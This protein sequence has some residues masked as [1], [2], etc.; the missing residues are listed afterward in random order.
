MHKIAFKYSFL[1][2][3]LCLLWL[4]CNKDV[5]NDF[6]VIQDEQFKYG[7]HTNPT[8]DAIGGGGCYSHAV[9]EGDYL[10]LNRS[11]LLDALSV[12]QAGEVV[13]VGP[14]AEIDLSGD[15]KIRIPEGVTLAGDRGNCNSDSEGPLLYANSM[16][17]G[18][19]LF[20]LRPGCR[21]TGLRF[22][23][24]DA[25]FSN[26]DYDIQPA[27]W[28]RC[29]VSWGEDIE[30]DNCEISNF[31]HSAISA[32]SGSANLHIHHNFLRDIHAYPVITLDYSSSSV[33][34]E[35][36]RIHWVW[37]AMAST[38]YP[39]TGYEARYNL[40]TRKPAPVSWENYNG[41][42][43]IDMHFFREVKNTRGHLISGNE[44][45]VHHNT[46]INEAAGDPSITL[47]LDAEISGVPRVLAEFHNNCFL[48][49][50]PATVKHEGGNTWV[51]N[52][53]Y[54]P[55]SVH[56]MRPMETTPQILFRNPPPPEGE[57]P[58]ITGE[59]LGVDIKINL[60]NLLE[61]DSV[62]IHLNDD[63]VYAAS[64]APA[65]GSLLLPLCDLES[66]RPFHELQVTAFDN[67][68][69]TGQHL[70]V[71]STNCP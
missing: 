67:R 15:S 64:S 39:V 8:G 46:F 23:G 10:V 41:G 71:F 2:L 30:V 6:P 38:G 44:M 13:L 37:T 54:G 17:E 33:L 47:A 14:G 1:A 32:N 61:L 24:P 36:N 55:D 57:I 35:A 66:S 60:L 65:P 11:E 5:F 16:P 31:H 63:V 50:D 68:G 58:A 27:S 56:I 3:M 49:A 9:T 53:L 26:I 20:W 52:N 4:A 48:Q 42:H 45:K 62:V 18:E 51:H 29:L 21:V 25:D 19:G 28:N 59:S 40:I 34:I 12:A 69:V 70:T 43:A 22:R 7:A